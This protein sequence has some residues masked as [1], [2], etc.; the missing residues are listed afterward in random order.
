MVAA[1]IDRFGSDPARVYVAGLSAGAAMTAALLAAYPDVFAAGAAVA[2]LPVGAATSTSEALIRM[3]EAGPARTPAAWAELVRRAAPAG[4]AG[5]WPRLSIW[6]GGADR[7][8]DPGNSRLM[9][10]QW[11]ALHGLDSGRISDDPSGGSRETWGPQGHPAVELWTLPG[12]PHIWPAGA[13]DRI[14]IFWG[15]Q[16][17]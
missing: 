13:A 5:P 14:A 6:H 1:S 7:V 17:G 16:Q 15:L 8:V 11:S 9:A 10:Q 12:L 4:Y 3:A 2:G